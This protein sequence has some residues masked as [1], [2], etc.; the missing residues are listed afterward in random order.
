M[1][2]NKTIRLILGI[3]GILVLG[4]ILWNVRSIIYYFFFAAIIAFI[5]RPVMRLLGRIT[6]K[7]WVIPN[8]L[9]STLVLTLIITIMYGSVSFIIPTVMHQ[10]QII[11]KIGQE[12]LM[13]LVNIPIDSVSSW[14]KQANIDEKEVQAV[15]QSKISSVFSMGDLGNYISNFLTT[16][17]Q[18][19]LALFSILFITFFLLKDG[20][21]VDNV[22]ES[23]TPDP[24]VQKI[25]TILFET[26]NLLS[27]YFI[28]VLIQVI[29]V[30][31]IITFGLT[32]LGVK[33]ALLIGL[34]A[35]VFNIIP[36]I[37]PLMGAA[38]GILL[39]LTSQLEISPELLIERFVLTAAIP[40]VVAQVLDNFVLQPLIFSKSV[41]AHP[42][43]IFMVIL[44]AGSLGGIVGMI[45]AVPS[46]SFIRILAKE[47]FNGYK[48]VQGLTKD[49]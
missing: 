21:I 19:V 5:V 47:F 15:L 24:Y 10:A 28:G 35:G 14:M 18:S 32:L 1:L 4:Y 49:L 22:I 43:E 40:F 11:S 17:T 27:R 25:Q 45:V 9:K 8:W 46:Y 7:S 2:Q 30:V 6:F 34:I 31:L 48:V 33:N 41:K 39:A 23:L 36:Y 3:L 12:N 16:I 37:G 42:L 26:K 44:A 20:S 38:L 13:E 29:V